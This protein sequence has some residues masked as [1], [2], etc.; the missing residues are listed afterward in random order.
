MKEYS[1]IGSDKEISFHELNSA[2]C[3]YQLIYLTLLSLYN[4]AKIDHTK[5][6]EEF[7]DWYADKY[8][9]IRHRENRSD[10]S[11]QKWVAAKELE[12]LVRKEFKEEYR[13]LNDEVLVADHK[14]SFLRRL[15]ESWQTQQYVLSQLSKNII[16]EVGS[17]N[18]E[19]SLNNR[20]T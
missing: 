3:N 17:T 13:A 5:K 6:K 11:A 8:I 12:M 2:L 15:L 14:V 20:G 10:M 7:D 4:V 18:T 9:D 19:N 1:H 16:A